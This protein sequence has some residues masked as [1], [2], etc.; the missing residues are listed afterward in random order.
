[1]EFLQNSPAMLVTVCVV[2]GLCVG[3][4]LNVVIHRV[5]R[6]ESLLRPGSHCPAGLLSCALLRTSLH[7]AACESSHADEG[8]ASTS[9][10]NFAD[11]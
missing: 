9:S 1:M 11:T 8:D 7:P 6:G 5:P 2:I 3:S 4:F 10:A